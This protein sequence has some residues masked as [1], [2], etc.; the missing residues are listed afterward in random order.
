LKEEYSKLNE[1]LELKHREIKKDSKS[2]SIS[3]LSVA[4]LLKDASAITKLRV[5]WCIE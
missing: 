4:S 1:Y 5:I 3:V 2:C